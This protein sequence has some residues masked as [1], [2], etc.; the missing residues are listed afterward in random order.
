MH[1][2]Y[3]IIP[4]IEHRTQNMK[5]EQKTKKEHKHKK[6]KERT[7]PFDPGERTNEPTNQQ[8]EE[9]ERFSSVLF[10]SLGCKRIH[11]FRKCN[12]P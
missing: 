9:K 2:T 1:K 4:Q 6:K 3:K 10:C 7:N 11:K 5:E 12:Q 8:T